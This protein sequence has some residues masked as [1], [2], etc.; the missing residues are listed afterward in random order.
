VTIYNLSLSGTVES[1][2]LDVLDRKINLFELVVG[3][4]DMILGELKPD[5]EFEDVVMDIWAGSSSG[6]SADEGF[7][8]L[9]EQLVEARQRYE[10]AVEYDSELFGEEL[11]VGKEE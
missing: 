1:E 8:E 3:E 9:G 7:E 11:R 6:R 10:S 5:R 4:L 2:L